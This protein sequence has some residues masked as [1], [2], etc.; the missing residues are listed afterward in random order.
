MRSAARPGARAPPPGAA[1]RSG[2]DRASGAPGRG[3]ASDPLGAGRP[4][5]SPRRPIAA[6]RG[7]ASTVARAAG[8]H[9]AEPPR[10]GRRSAPRV[11]RCPGVVPRGGG[12]PGVAPALSRRTRSR[13]IA[14]FDPAIT[15]GYGTL[16]HR[17]IFAQA[18]PRP[19]KTAAAKVVPGITADGI[20]VPRDRDAGDDIGP[21][22]RGHDRAPHHARADRP[23]EGGAEGG[24]R[25]VRGA[26]PDAA[27]RSGHGVIAG[28]PP[29]VGAGSAGQH[30]RRRHAMNQHRQ[31][32]P[33]QHY[34]GLDVS[35]DATSVCVLDA[36]GA[37]GASCGGVTRTR[38][39]P[40]RK[41]PAVP[42]KQPLRAASLRRRRRERSWA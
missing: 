42:T 14:S 20:S 2:L 13:P 4:P 37:V 17:V 11:H 10:G 24:G 12:T 23:T 31:H 29:G 15:P 19:G 33:G 22:P 3:G 7:R 16:G 5:A 18:A 34:A 28:E 32:A 38:S 21:R 30:R 9:R 36:K 35:L 26:L 1:G 41:R 27:G 8:V 39:A 40:R 25:R 6:G